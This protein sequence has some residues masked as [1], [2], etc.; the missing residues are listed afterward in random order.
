MPP[1]SVRAMPVALVPEVQRLQVLFGARLRDAARDAVE[2]G[3]VDERVIV[4]LEHVEVDLLRH[5][6]DAGLRRLALALEVVAEHAS[7][8]RRTCG[9][10]T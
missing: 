4:A 3:L 7:P 10:A 9:P 1:D 6:A 2:A 5:D 8:S